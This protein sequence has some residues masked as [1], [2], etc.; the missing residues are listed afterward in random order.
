MTTRLEKLKKL[1]SLK[2]DLQDE[3]LTVILEHTEGYLTGLL[4]LGY[5]DSSL[6][7]IVVEVAVKRYNRVGA[8]GYESKRI[9]GLDIT[10]K[11]SD[12]SEYLPILKRLYPDAF[13][14]SGV[15]FI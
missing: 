14:K 5:V 12:F 9:E 1:L 11:D 7:F 13:G 4:N 6:D 3:L 10:F 15:R 2:D 8:E